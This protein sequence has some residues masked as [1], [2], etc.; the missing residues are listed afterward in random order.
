MADISFDHDELRNIAYGIK[1]D[2]LQ[3]LKD[4][5][6]DQIEN[7]ISYAKSDILD[8]IDYKISTGVDMD[9][10]PVLDQVNHALKNDCCTKVDDFINGI[11][12]CIATR[13]ADFF[14]ALTRKMFKDVEDYR[15]LGRDKQ[16]RIKEL[17]EEILRLKKLMLCDAKDCPSPNNPDACTKGEDCAR[18]DDHA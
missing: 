8:D 9:Y 16:D 5:V 4:E 14:N 7:E 6:T 17:Q 13:K 11:I 1:D 12:D 10:E 3:E 2:L 15:E 18:G